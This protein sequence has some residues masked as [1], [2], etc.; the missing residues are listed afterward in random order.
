MSSHPWLNDRCEEAINKKN[1]AEGSDEF[2]AARLAC[3]EIL[4]TE[5]QKYVEKV[6]T[7]LATLKRGSLNDSV[8]QPTPKSLDFMN[9]PEAIPE[10]VFVYFGS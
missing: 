9:Y 5:H 10:E 8:I 4:A 6:R 7:K 1:E 3:A 2:E